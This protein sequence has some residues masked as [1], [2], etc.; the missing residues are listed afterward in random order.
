MKKRKFLVGLFIA[1]TLVAAVGVGSGIV[2]LI[3]PPFGTIHFIG[4]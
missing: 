2:P 3:D 1:L 4:L